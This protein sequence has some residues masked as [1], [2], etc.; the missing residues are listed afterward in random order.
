MV[1]KDL[2]HWPEPALLEKGPAAE[3]AEVAAGDGG[4]WVRDNKGRRIAVPEDCTVWG[5]L[6]SAPCLGSPYPTTRQTPPHKPSPGQL[7][8]MTNVYVI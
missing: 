3:P 5:L 7:L 8:F 1:Y 2:L 4:G 6:Q